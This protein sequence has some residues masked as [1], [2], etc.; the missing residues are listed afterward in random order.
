MKPCPSTR[1]PATWR[2]VKVPGL[3]KELGT[4][5]DWVL[6]GG[7]SVAL[8]AGRDTRR[9]GDIDI[10]VFRSQL[11]RCLRALGQER[12]FLCRNGTHVAW[13]GT[14]VPA[15]VHDIWITDRAGEFWALQVMVFDDHGGTVIYRRDRR[16]RWPKR[17]HAISIDG[18][19]VL[20]PFVTFLFKANQAARLRAKDIHDFGKLIAG[21][22]SLKAKQQKP[23]TTK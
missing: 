7:H 15:D 4:F 11:R 5:R 3:Q 14:A 22:L 23:R 21:P 2:P 20:N 13:R 8:L 16:L 1:L 9:H 19:R 18:V 12:V 10:G 6:C 17:Y